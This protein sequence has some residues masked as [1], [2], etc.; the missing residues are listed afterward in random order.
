M[1]QYTIRPPLK[2]HRSQVQHASLGLGKPYPRE[3]RDIV[4]WRHTN[5]LP[6]TDP[7]LRLMQASKEY[8]CDRTISRY[9]LQYRAV[10]HVIPFRRTGNNRAQRD[11]KGTDLISLA[12]HRSIRPKSRI[13]EVKAFVHMVNPANAVY[14]DSQICRAEARLGL[15]RK[16]G[17]TT[18]FQAYLPINVLKRQNYFRMDY[19]GGIANIDPRDVID[20][21]EA[22]IHLE[23]QDRSFG[24]TV[25]G[26][27]CDQAG[28]Y[29]RSERLNT[30]LGISGD[31]A[32]ASRWVN[33]WSG[34]G[35]TL[36]RFSTFLDEVLNDLD[37]RFPG[38]VFCFVMDNLN[39][40]KHPHIVGM[41]H[42][43]GH[44]LI[45]RAPYYA[46]D[47]AIEYV[48]N[49]LHSLLEVMYNRISNMQDLETAV[50]DCIRSM[51]T[52]VPYFKHVGFKY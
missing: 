47:G 32:I 24:K 23:S 14:S 8:P 20:I 6:R 4:I 50:E 25:E 2:T 18:A 35:T 12:L 37:V 29:N 34:E 41:I 10:V 48:F 44:R 28:H 46:I 1:R 36:F 49:T 13:Y 17:S 26:D 42:N 11:V 40:H 21:D 39:T 19:P 5:G 9:I 7:V 33:T 31:D 38:R 3:T 22:G 16:K 15:T 30:L 27:R 51:T 45:Y 43:R 52:F